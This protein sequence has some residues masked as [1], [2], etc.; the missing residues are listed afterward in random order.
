MGSRSM[1]DSRK[2]ESSSALSVTNCLLHSWIPSGKAAARTRRGPDNSHSPAAREPGG[3][4][5]TAL[6]SEPSCVRR[7]E[8]PG[9][10]KPIHTGSMY[11][12]HWASTLEG[13]SLLIHLAVPSLHHTSLFAS[14]FQRPLGCPSSDYPFWRSGL[15]VRYHPYWNT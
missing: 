4:V 9:T 7:P 10:H 3:L 13:S 2:L 1:W 11:P 6:A 12:S 15:G 14:G 5:F 8:K